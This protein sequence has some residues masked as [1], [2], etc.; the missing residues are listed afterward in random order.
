MLSTSTPL[1]FQILSA[2]TKDVFGAD[3]R[4]TLF[5]ATAT[6]KSVS[7]DVTGFEPYFYV[8]LPEDWSQKDRNAYQRYLCGHLSDTDVEKVTLTIEHHR[9][10]WDFTNNQSFPF[11]KVQTQTKKLW[12]ALRDV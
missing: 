1:C 5:G 10:F 2:T 8:Q 12:N 6:G 9:S 7:L 4:I 3:Y 11:L